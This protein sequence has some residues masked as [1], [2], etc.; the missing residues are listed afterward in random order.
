MHTGY[1]RSK[2]RFLSKTYSIRHAKRSF[3]AIIFI[4]CLFV[5]VYL[6]SAVM[7][8]TSFTLNTSILNVCL[9]TA[10]PMLSDNTTSLVL[11]N[12]YDI[13]NSVFPA[14]RS[15]DAMAKKYAAKW[16]ASIRAKRSDKKSSEVEQKTEE[17]NN[18][19][20]Q[21]LS[22]AA[23]G[24]TF[25]NATEYSVDANT[26]LSTPLA[27]ASKSNEPRVLIVHTHTSEA[28]ADSP[29]G[30]S[31]DD[32]QNVVRIGKEIADSLNRAG[33]ITI[34]D[35]T[36][37]DQPDYN[38]SYKNALSIIQKNLLA[39]PSLEI[40][41][42]VH[43]DYTVRDA[44]TPSELHLKPT[45]T[46]NGKNAAQIMFVMGTDAMDLHHPDWRHNLSFAVKIQNRLNE[47][48]P[49]LCR[50]I[51]IRTERFNQHMTKGSMIIEVG[52]STNTLNE[53]I[54]AGGYI[55]EAIAD[56]LNKK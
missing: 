33:I 30:R 27:F 32:S 43:R 2:R 53:A 25:N 23:K 41:L 48:H 17:I 49:N 47:I 7:H 45:Q 3:S 37:N 50:P 40:V 8:S 16:D 42:D 4:I 1:K 20:V 39:H 24:L 18:I 6:L 51:N 38:G 55:A 52:S 29:G 34:H 9:R 10:F 21:T 22:M 15:N 28:Y 36:K 14:I 26:L 54:R 11:P 35:T 12:K 5:S 46:E 13:I 31:T 44:G 19:K 56:V